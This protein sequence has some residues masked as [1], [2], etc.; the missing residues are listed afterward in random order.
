MTKTM[1]RW[2]LTAAGRTNL[3]LVETAIPSPGPGEILI[4]VGAVSLNYRDKLLV[5]DGFGLP[6]PQMEPLIPLSDISGTVAALGEGVTRF[7]TGD[8]VISTFLPD[9]IDGSG[10]G[11]ARHPNGRTLGGSLQGVLAEYVVLNQDWAVRGPDAL[12]DVEASTL[13]C[14]GL[15][16]WTALVERGKLRAGQKVVVLGTGG[17]SL[18]GLQ[19]GLMH[20]AEVIVVSGDDK[21]LARARELGAHHAINRKRE[22]WVEAV[23]RLTGD[24]G[25]D[26]ILE[27]VGGAH[28]GKSLN[29]AAV[30]GRISLIGI[31][32]G[33]DVSGGFGAFARKRLV[34]EGIQVGHR[35]ALE[36]LVRAFD[37]SGTKPVIDAIYKMDEFEAALD[38][39]DRG[40]FGKIVVEAG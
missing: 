22:D 25:A 30:A 12:S 35:R 2:Q 13:P 29:A 20:G 39:L 23:Y 33:L 19:I 9:W 38:H 4:K 14:A 28:L 32:E 31:L 27:T 24:Y 18:F 16:A 5:D 6:D 17:V 8:R 15:T 36:D 40:P 11:T 37:L 26:H 7:A 3:K 1:K 34:V 21:K 10:P